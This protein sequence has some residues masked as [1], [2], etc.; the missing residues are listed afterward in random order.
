MT[1]IRRILL[2]LLLF[3]GLTSMADEI[4]FN[5]S[6]PSIVSVGDQFSLTLVLNAKGENLRMPNIDGF[7][8]L[9]G[10]SVS[11]STSMQIIN[12]SVSRSVSYSYTYVLKAKS[13]GTFTILPA[14]IEVKR[15][16]YQSNSV[17]IQV[18]KGRKPQQTTQ[19]QQQNNNQESFIKAKPFWLHLNYTVV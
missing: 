6:A 7:D 3:T 19:G 9:M 10:P 17:K 1:M 15:K 8:I 2:I 5:M 16:I 14:S 4:N 12:G 18:I 13:E 11:S